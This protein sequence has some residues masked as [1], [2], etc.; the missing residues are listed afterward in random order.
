MAYFAELDE[1]D[2]VIR[3]VKIENQE[4][5]NDD[6]EEDENVGITFLKNLYGHNGIWI[7]TSY[8]SNFRKNYASVGCKYERDND[9]FIPQ[10]T[11]ESWILNQQ[12]FKW[13][14]PVKK[15]NDGKSYYWDESRISWI[16]Y[17]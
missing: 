13:E 2:I 7:Q 14:P 1:N 16:E 17:K 11:L 10:K 5:I 15:P 8:N 4:N 6:G 12:T 3:V 9:A